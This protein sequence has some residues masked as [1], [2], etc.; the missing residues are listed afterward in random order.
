MVLILY[1]Q[2]LSPVTYLLQQGHTSQASPNSA[3]NWRPSIR[4]PQTMGGISHANHKQLS[5]EIIFVCCCLFLLFIY[6]RGLT[7]YVAQAGLR[8]HNLAPSLFPS[9]GITI[10]PNSLYKCRYTPTDKCT[11]SSINIYKR[12]TCFNIN[13]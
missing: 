11:T 2:S 12:S 6:F 7:N 10:K 13:K 9:A 5:K 4:I 3:T 1:S 8:L